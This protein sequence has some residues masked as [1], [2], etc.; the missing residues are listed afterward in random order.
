MTMIR[1]RPAPSSAQALER[2]R[3]D[4]AAEKDLRRVADL[5]GIE[6]DLAVARARDLATAQALTFAET[7]ASE[8]RLIRQ[9]RI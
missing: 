2:A 5:R 6:P 1:L 9:H 8:I 7:A 3:L 4:A